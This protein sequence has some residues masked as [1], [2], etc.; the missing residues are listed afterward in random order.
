M[1]ERSTSTN[2]AEVLEDINGGVFLQQ[3][4]AALS[5]VALGTVTYGDKG[6]AGKA[7]VSFSMK[8]IGESNQLMLVSTLEYQQPT[9]RGKKSE[10]VTIETP[11]HVGRGGKLS[12]MPEAA[13]QIDFVQ[14][15]RERDFPQATRTS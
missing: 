13:E 5:A 14:Q 1:N 12:L 7:N 8:R 11:M 2:L 6:K 10:T 4:E 15:Q 3:F 9:S